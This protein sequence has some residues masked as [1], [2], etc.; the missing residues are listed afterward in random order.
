[1]T[2]HDH[3][4][5]R[6]ACNERTVDGQL[7]G[8][9]LNDDGT[10]KVLPL[11]DR[12]AAALLTGRLD[13][14]EAVFDSETALIRD[15]LVQRTAAHQRVI[16]ERDGLRI[17]LADA[18]AGLLEAQAALADFR[19]HGTRFDLNPTHRFGDE[20]FWHGYLLRIDAGIRQRAGIALG[21]CD[22]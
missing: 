18:R 5:Y 10:P 13:A 17:E 19:D 14:I 22:E 6:P 1:M 4:P 15:T 2:V 12:L 11:R 7:R 16:D 3:P 21:L 9:C 8:A 20:A